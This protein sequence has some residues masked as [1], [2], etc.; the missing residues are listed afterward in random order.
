MKVTIQSVERRDLSGSKNGR[1][2][3]M[4]DTYIGYL[5]PSETVDFKGSRFV[6]LQFGL[7]SNFD[8]LPS[9]PFDADIVLGVGFNNR[10]EPVQVIEK[11]VPVLPA[12][13][14]K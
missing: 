9:P 14:Q 8:K 12:S 10:G 4:D 11:C 5:V 13:V 6:T 7:S 3:K 2:W 1:D